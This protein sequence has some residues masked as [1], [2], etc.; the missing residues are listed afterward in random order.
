M[1]HFGGTTTPEMDNNVEELQGETG[2]Q[3]EQK[4]S[5]ISKIVQ[6]YNRIRA[7]KAGRIGVRLLKVGG[8]IAGGRYLYE[9][10][11]K[12]VQ[13]VVVTI[14]EGVDETADEAGTLAEAEAAEKE[15]TEE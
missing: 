1:K 3:Q 15:K 2:G 4:K 12:S 11:R 6:G 10:G 5:V 9:A 14:K 7:T 8:L 13:P